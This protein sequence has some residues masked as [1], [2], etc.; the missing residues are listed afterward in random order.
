MNYYGLRRVCVC[1]CV[2]VYT[3]FCERRGDFGRS[4]NP[5]CLGQEGA[6]YRQMPAA[7]VVRS[8]I[9][10]TLKVSKAGLSHRA[11]GDSGRKM[12][13][14]TITG[15]TDGGPNWDSPAT[16]CSVTPDGILTH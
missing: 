13:S 3:S 4:R 11:K 8:Q 6:R 12:S 16:Q 7:V 10:G 9:L 5:N 2:C 15:E 1:V 14:K